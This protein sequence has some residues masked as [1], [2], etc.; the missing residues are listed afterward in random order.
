MPASWIQCFFQLSLI[1]EDP[2]PIFSYGTPCWAVPVMT[3]RRGIYCNKWKCFISHFIPV[4]ERHK[5]REHEQWRCSSSTEGHS[6]QARVSGKQA[7][8]NR[9]STCVF[10][11][12]A[13][14]KHFSVKHQKCNRSSQHNYE[15][16]TV[17]TLRWCLCIV[18][19]MY[20]LKLACSQAARS[21]FIHQE[22]M[23]GL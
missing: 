17:L 4:G 10:F 3:L 12:G 2:L 8:I 6:A 20:L 21:Q 22:V 14:C 7:H 18:L 13:I 11:R 1:V 19:Q 16:I 9:C 5:L 23:V 15:E